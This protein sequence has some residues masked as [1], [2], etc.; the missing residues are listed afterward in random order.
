MLQILRG[1]TPTL[2]LKVSTDD[3]SVEDVVKLKINVWT[4]GG[5]SKSYGLEDV[6]V[7]KYANRFSI[8][9]TESDTLQMKNDDMMYWQMRCAFEDGNIIGTAISE[10]VGIE[11]LKDSEAMSDE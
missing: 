6:D 10:P 8:R 11:K 1:T 4:S 9:F 3:F 7:D 5:F 2:H